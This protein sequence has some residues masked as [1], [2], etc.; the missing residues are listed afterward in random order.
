MIQIEINGIKCVALKGD[1]VIE[2]AKKFNVP[3]PRF[4]YHNKLSI[5][6]NCRMCLVEIE[7]MAKLSPACTTLVVDGMKIWTRSSKAIAAQK[8]VLEFLLINHPLDCPVCDQGGECEL[9]DITISYG[10]VTSRFIEN[11]RVVN[12]DNLGNLIVTDMTRCILCSRCVRFGEEIVGVVDLG[13]VGRGMFSRV[14]TFVEKVM[15]SELSGNII[16]ICPVGALTS[17]LFR[18]KAR[19]WELRQYSTISLH[20]CIGS[21]LYG[22]SK[23]GTL[24]RIVPREN[25]DLND[26]W[27]SDRDRF[28][29]EAIYS[30]D[31]LLFPIIKENGVWKEISLN[32]ALLFF[33]EKLKKIILN[34]VNNIGILASPNSTLEEFYLLQKIFRALNVNNIDH[35]LLDVDFSI[36][37]SFPLYLGTGIRMKDIENSDCILLLGSYI[38][39]EQPIVILRII[40]AINHGAKICSIGESYYDYPFNVDY[41]NIVKNN[42]YIFELFGIIKALEKRKF[43]VPSSII[44]LINDK[45]N[46][47]YDNSKLLEYLI[48]SKNGIFILGLSV[49]CNLNFTKI[50]FLVNTLCNMLNFKFILMTYGSN[51]AGGWISGFVPHRLP[52]GVSAIKIGYT[53][54]EMFLNGVKNYL[55]FGFE[56]N[57]DV[58]NK[59]LA[60]EILNKADYVVSITVFKSKELLLISDLLIP[61]ASSYETSGTFINVFGNWQSFDAVAIPYKNTLPGWKVLAKLGSLLKMSSFDNYTSTI[62]ILNELKILKKGCVIE[63][64]NE[65]IKNWKFDNFTNIIEDKINEVDFMP[66]LYKNDY[67]VR[68]AKSLYNVGNFSN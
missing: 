3:I 45:F 19:P 15:I 35:R 27:I 50:L 40:K 33:I 54:S 7:K 42:D 23:N 1:L 13:I 12:N 60:M 26:V 64:L 11:K 53:V 51:S 61:I 36:Q 52:L 24:M 14:T 16:D 32:D 68:R 10:C 37:N 44:N 5:A 18:Y 46:I 4:C 41:I 43:I 66:L 28:S 25:Y 39:K 6:A 62:D 31:R 65:V 48:T 57:I 2:V 17:K 47:I 58:Y 49:Y 34:D 20:D 29:Y 38:N 22:H 8:A 9:Q 59:N 21:N 30:E 56:P 63:E 67:L 55:L